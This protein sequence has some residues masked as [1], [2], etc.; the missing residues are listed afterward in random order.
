MNVLALRLAS[1]V[2]VGSRSL[3]W[4]RTPTAMSRFNCQW[5]RISRRQLTIG[6][7]L[8]KCKVII[9][10]ENAN[11]DAKRVRRRG[12]KRTVE[13]DV[14]KIGKLYPCDWTGCVERFRTPTLLAK[15]MRF[16]TIPRPFPCDWEGCAA[17][18]Q[19]AE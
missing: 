13:I 8:P 2:T 11:V 12:G 9:E 14:N 17:T 4:G 10:P 5:E 18:L 15:H 16:H 19:G 7:N 6:T 3:R 1:V